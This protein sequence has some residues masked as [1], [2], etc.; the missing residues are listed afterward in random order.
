MINLAKVKQYVLKQL[1]EN[2]SKDF[3]Y[4][5]IDHTIDVFNSVSRLAKMAKIDSHSL[6][7]VQTSALFHDIGLI[8]CIDKHEERGVEII[9]ELL[10]SFGYQTK[11]IEQIAEM[12][13]A[14]KL[15]QTPKSNLA[16][17]LC[18][19]DLDYLGR[20]DFFK[21][22]TELHLE[23]Q[24]MKIMDVPFDEW[25]SIQKSFLQSHTFFTKEARELRNVGKANNLKQLEG[26]CEFGKRL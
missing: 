12:I 21:T 24:R 2:L 17:L 26:I 19:A 10:P 6:I 3:I 16:E 14:T 15:P 20:D 25:I 5:N 11:D 1:E 18:D 9:K 8:D 4:H 7:L 13:L 23:W 22:G